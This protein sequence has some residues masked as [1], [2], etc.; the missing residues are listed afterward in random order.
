MINMGDPVLS[1]D[2]KFMWT[3][4]QWIPAPPGQTQSSPEP[5]S[6]NQTPK[7]PRS[8]SHNPYYTE[9]DSEDSEN[10]DSQ[11]LSLASYVV[12][13]NGAVLLLIIFIAYSYMKADVEPGWISSYDYLVLKVVAVCWV[14]GII[15]SVYCRVT[16]AIA[17]DE[18][19][20]E[21][22]RMLNKTSTVL[23]ALPLLPI[24]LLM[25]VFYLTMKYGNTGTRH[26]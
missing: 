11:I 9:V 18:V 20:V 24:A 26:Y 21:Q 16:S 7:S 6:G 3:G 2:G 5:S 14:I 8:E 23:L 13:W 19:A 12:G 17:E 22:I 1:P 25:L 10:V 4:E 15:L